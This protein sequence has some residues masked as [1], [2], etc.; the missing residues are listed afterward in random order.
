M[1][2]MDAVTREYTHLL[3]SQ[4]ESQRLYFEDLRAQDS[5]AHAAH[6]AE[7]EGTSQG[8][9]E[10]A[11]SAGQRCDSTDPLLFVQLVTNWC[12]CPWQAVSPL[13]WDTRYE[14][15]MIAHTRMRNQNCCH[16][17]P[18]PLRASSGCTSILTSTCR[19]MQGRTG[20]S[21]S[22]GI[23][24]AAEGPEWPHGEEQERTGSAE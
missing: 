18:Y 4:L 23:A 3:T 19:A 2:K 16:L 12:V 13:A 20:R 7:L 9:S 17:D 24:K 5:A 10:A 1:S 21:G 15:T 11:R 6:V 8:A 22:E 14:R